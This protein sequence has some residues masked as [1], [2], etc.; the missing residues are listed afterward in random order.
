MI[1]SD[2]RLSMPRYDARS[3]RWEG[4]RTK[5]CELAEA[6]DVEDGQDKRNQ[7]DDAEE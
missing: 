5:F 2:R 6:A 3:C 1:D 4:P 7:A